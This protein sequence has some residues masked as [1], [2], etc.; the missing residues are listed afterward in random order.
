MSLLRDPPTVLGNSLFIWFP[1]PP[2]F[3]LSDDSS[4]WFLGLSIVPP[5]SVTDVLCTFLWCCCF[6]HQQLLDTVVLCIVNCSILML[7]YR[8]YLMLSQKFFKRIFNV[9]LLLHKNFV[10]SQILWDVP[11]LPGE[12]AFHFR[13]FWCLCFSASITRIFP[14]LIT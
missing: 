8:W 10:S 3:T 13:N 1:S 6:A 9:L 14:N 11:P 7:A 5:K 12:I 2:P 4:V